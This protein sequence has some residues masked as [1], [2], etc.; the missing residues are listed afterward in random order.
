MVSWHNTANA[1]V[2]S[3]STPVNYRVISKT[4]IAPDVETY[5]FCL[6]QNNSQIFVPISLLLS[7]SCQLIRRYPTSMAAH[8]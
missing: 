5:S 8:G 6:R 7:F 1:N 4:G 3:I 2:I